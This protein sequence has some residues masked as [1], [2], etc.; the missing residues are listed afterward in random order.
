M[1]AMTNE[2]EAY[3]LQY[4]MLKSYYKCTFCYIALLPGLWLPIVASLVGISFSNFQHSYKR[5][6]RFSVD[7]MRYKKICEDSSQK[8]IIFSY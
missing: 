5:V 3:I 8:K 4:M 6:P 1:V 2:G 7:M